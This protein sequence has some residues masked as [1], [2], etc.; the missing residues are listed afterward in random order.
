MT[1]FLRGSPTLLKRSLHS[2]LRLPQA[3]GEK[4]ALAQQ[5]LQRVSIVISFF[6]CIPFFSTGSS[7]SHLVSFPSISHTHTHARRSRPSQTTSRSSEPKS[8]PSSS[9]ESV[10]PRPRMRTGS[11]TRNL[12]CPWY[13]D[14]WITPWLIYLAVTIRCVSI[15]LLRRLTSPSC[16]PASLLPCFPA[17][18]Q[19]APPLLPPT[20]ATT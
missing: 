6:S 12:N 14:W 17:P 4:H 15:P 8:R 5:V 1:T 13:L 7:V 2:S 20:T 11:P 18:N 3:A 10:E 16:F 19:L 9:V